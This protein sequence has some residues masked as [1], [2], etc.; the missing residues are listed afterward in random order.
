[1]ELTDRP[2]RLRGSDA[3]RR[4]CR[5]TRMSPDSLIYPIFVDETLSGTRPIDALPGQFHYGVDSV[6]RAVEACLEAGVGRCILFGLPAKKD[7]QGSSAWA[8]KGVV[9]EAVRAI[10]ISLPRAAA[11]FSVSFLLAESLPRKIMPLRTSRMV[12][13]IISSIS[14]KPLLVLSFIICRLPAHVRNGSSSLS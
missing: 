1:M 11:Y 5:E 10:K 12:M 9:Q 4:M 6:C 7:A 2:R 8:K 14:E 13:A 3:I